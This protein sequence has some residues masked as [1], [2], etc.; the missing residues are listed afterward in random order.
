[1]LNALINLAKAASDI[2]T[3]KEVSMYHTGLITIDGT[4]NGGSD[5]SVT[6]RLKDAE[7]STNGNP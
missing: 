3:V 1:M 5:F 7:E 4:T 2:G 6:Y